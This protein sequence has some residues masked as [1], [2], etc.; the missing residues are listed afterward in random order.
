[1]EMLAIP[2]QPG[3]STEP[4]SFP[5]ERY[6]P[7]VP[8]GMAAAWLQK[9]VPPGS[10]ILDPFCSS[11]QAVL[12][13]ARAGYRVIAACNNPVV[14]FLTEILAEAPA[15]ADFNA[16]LA[17]LAMQKRGDDRLENVLQ[18]LYL[19]T[20]PGCNQKVPAEAFLWRKGEQAPYAKI[21][22]CPACLWD[23]EAGTDEFDFQVLS[24]SANDTINRARA[25]QRV[26]IGDED[27]RQ[28]ARE[29]LGTYQPRQINFLFTLINKIQTLDMPPE[30]KNLL[31]VLFLVLCDEGNMMWSHPPG[32]V[33]PRQISVPSEYQEVNLWLMMERTAS[34]WP[35]SPGAVPCQDYRL[36]K[37]IEQGITL[38]PGRV[39]DMLPLKK[40]MDVSAVVSIFPRPNQAFWTYSALWSGWIWGTE[41]VTPLRSSLQRKRYGWQWHANALSSTFS[42]LQSHLQG[43]LPFWG[44]VAESNPGFLAAILAASENNGLDLSGLSWNEDDQIA[45]LWWKTAAL[46]QYSE[47][48]PGLGKYIRQGFRSYLQARAEP[49]GYTHLF[50]AGILELVKEKCLARGLRELPFNQITLLQNQFAANFSNRSLLRRY[51]SESQNQETGLWWLEEVPSDLGISLSDQVELAIRSTLQQKEFCDYQVLLND[52]NKTFPGLLTPSQELLDICLESYARPKPT[53]SETWLILG[54]EKA[55]IRQADENEAVQLLQACA[56]RLGLSVQTNTQYPAAIDWHTREGELVFRFYVQ[57]HAAISRLVH[58][59]HHLAEQGVIVFPGSRSNLLSFKLQKNPYLEEQVNLGW[60]F[61]KFRTLRTIANRPELTLVNWKELLDGDPPRW[62][63]PQQLSFFST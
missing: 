29:A 57:S 36:A 45:Q 2:Y 26:E 40:G 48:K 8:Q 17:E 37:T 19:T 55:D 6:L 16:A 5:L 14:R 32:R 24:Q 35:E 20:C 51:E 41:A 28:G 39:R 27:A 56:E 13:A 52:L 25:L 61:L 7:P 59:P 12:E 10:I 31:W 49:A 18:N 30:Q 4:P 38:Y 22:H 15:A 43:G 9:Q 46:P 42:V 21:V 11:P 60:H 58:H 47:E 44:I 34:Q 23:G 63:Q 33:R 62:E 50:T 3:E 53:H 54:A 1:M